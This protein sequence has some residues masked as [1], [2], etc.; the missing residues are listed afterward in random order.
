M[1]RVIFD[2]NIYGHLINE[3]DAEVLEQKIIQEPEFVVYGFGPIRK[4]IR[5]ISTSS[6]LGRQTRLYLLGLYDRIT[7]S[8]TLPESSRVM[9]LAK[10]YHGRYQAAG[11]AYGWDT[12]IQIDFI[13]VACASIHGLDIIYSRDKRTMG[14]VKAI[15]AYD[16]VNQKENVRTPNLI[17]YELLVKKFRGLL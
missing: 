11:G 14:N 13:I 12:N 7:K 2:T 5:N 1:L 4:E 8:H 6:R 16:A 15:R 17:D 3:P 10:E 9:D